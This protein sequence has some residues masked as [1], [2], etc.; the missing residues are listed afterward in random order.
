[1]TRAARS[2]RV[3]IWLLGTLSGIALVG[4]AIWSVDSWWFRNELA[5]AQREMDAA[6]YGAAR[7]RLARLAAH[8]P[9]SGE[10]RYRLGVCEQSLGHVDAA[11]AAWK[12]VPRNAPDAGRAAVAAAGVLWRQGRLAPAEDLLAAARVQPG[13]H[14]PEATQML[15]N[16]LSL[17][18]RVDEVRPLIGHLEMDRDPAVVLIRL[19]KLDNDPYPI[20]GLRAQLE[21]AARHAPDDDRVWLGRANLA[22]RTGHHAEARE[23]L[24]LCR[25]SRPADPAVC[26]ARLDCALAD[27]R[28]DEVPEALSSLPPE[29]LRRGEA[30][31]LR[32]QIAL[33]G[34][35]ARAEE[36]ALN[37]RLEV[38]PGDTQAV[39][40]L[41]ELARLAGDSH[42]AEWLHSRKS[43]LDRARDR[44]QKVLAALDPHERT[45]DALELA[46][47]AETLGRQ[48]EARGWATLARNDP[49]QV[50][51][52][53]AILA[54]LDRSEAR[55]PAPETVLA[56]LRAD[57]ARLPISGRVASGS[58]RPVHPPAFSDDAGSSGLR[59]VFENG[60]SPERQLPETMAGGVGLF[61]YDGDGWLD[62]YVVQGGS[63]PPEPSPP[64]CADRL[65][66]NRRDGTFVDVTRE[67]RI[68]GFAGGYGHGVAVVDYDNDGRPDLFV[69][70]WRSYA[71]YRNLGGTFADVTK[72]AGLGGDRDWPTSAAWA[73]L[74]GDGDLDLYVCHYLEWDAHSPRLCRDRA[75]QVVQYCNPR[76]FAARA[77]H[78]FRN[79]GG[80]FVDVTSASGIVDRDG[81]GLGVVAADLDQDGR[82]DL[83][84]AND[85]TANYF[86]R[87]LGGLRFQEIG[88]AAGVATN[89]SGGYQAGMGVACGDLDG[90]G[91]PDLAVT[92]FYGESTT[93]FRNLGGGFFGD[94][95]RAVGLEAPSRYL[96]GF[97]IAFLDADNDGRLDVATANAHVEDFR[98]LIPYAMPAQLLL[99]GENGRLVDVSE[100]AG[101]PWRVP[102]IGR[103][104]AAGDLDN[105]GRVDL[106]LLGQGEPLAY[107]H[108]RSSAGHCLTLRLEGTASNRDA[109]GA[110][111]TVTSCGQ[112][113]H[114]WRVGGGSYQSASES[115]LHF[116]LGRNRNVESVEVRW[117][118]GRVDQYRDLRADASFLLREGQPA[119]E[120]IMDHQRRKLDEPTKPRLRE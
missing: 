41:A 52:A 87:N 76:F 12:A 118:S 54:R 82:V 31:G 2:S 94:G 78:L 81:R 93:F 95:T 84:V 33:R 105:D 18:G 23:W 110:H 37:A 57:L 113:R 80:R 66:R 34:G 106:L 11:L 13:P 117:P 51:D 32:A 48:L 114:A 30:L 68:A 60:R 42:R 63:F 5:Q 108:N 10:A 8:R 70:R 119:P 97:G 49:A 99:G 103:G 116:G 67:A 112:P 43:E 45:A 17:E 50:Q 73:D 109:V 56:E 61:D 25:K 69:T 64:R 35:D 96:L 107:L 29:A 21:E 36:R 27:D 9:S 92:N 24:E 59:F 40:R 1:V 88:L 4:V 15:A 91:R 47:L 89:A 65:F 62:V 20:E 58:V 90:D 22:I 120:W 74:D 55:R 14:V 72:A 38:E 83:F 102:R 79:D 86:Y 26:R 53:Q 71:L 44:Y 3:A 75:T 28:F 101:P 111:V 7:K 98:P 39:A 100:G 16:I 19:W 115:R 104:L 46:R 85:T 6:R 77:D